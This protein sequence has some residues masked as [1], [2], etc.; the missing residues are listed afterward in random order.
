MKVSPQMIPG[1]VPFSQG[2]IIVGFLW[3]FCTLYGY[4]FLLFPG[5][6]IHYF[7]L[8]KY[9]PKELKILQNDIEV[10]T[11]QSNLENAIKFANDDKLEKAVISLQKIPKNSNLYKEAQQ[12]IIEYQQKHDEYLFRIAQDLG[13]DNQMAD[14]IANLE[15]AISHLQKIS[16]NSNLHEKSQLIQ[17]NYYKEIENERKRRKVEFSGRSVE[18]IKI[19][20]LYNLSSKN[21]MCETITG[22]IILIEMNFQNTSKKTCNFQFSDFKIIDGNECIYDELFDTTYTMWRQEKGF[23]MRA[24]D[25][26]P[27]EIRQEVACFRVSPTAQNFCLKWNGQKITLWI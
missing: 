24:E 14:K 1:F 6:I 27:G 8:K 12:K 2:K 23:K 3:L 26:Y 10:S 11:A 13:K 19:L 20:Q 15:N 25:Y 22:R 18:I 21:P 17:T 7:Y 16:S 5:L 9:C 4:L